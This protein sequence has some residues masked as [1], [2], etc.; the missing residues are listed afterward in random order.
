M[1]ESQLKIAAQSWLEHLGYTCVD[2]TSLSE[3]ADPERM[4][5][6]EVILRRRLRT[7]LVRLN[8][9]IPNDAVEEAFRKL[10]DTPDATSHIAV[11][12]S[13][14][15]MIVEGVTVECRRGDGTFGATQ[16]RVLD[17]AQAAN[18]DWLAVRQ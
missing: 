13:I 18:N 14:H 10:T 17:L 12:W 8:P 7:A 1:Y 16:V 9:D 4:D 2:G 6:S 5:L 3:G 11:N 15:R